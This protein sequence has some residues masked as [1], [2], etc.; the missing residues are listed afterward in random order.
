MR[1][2][3]HDNWDCFHIMLVLTWYL[4]SSVLRSMELFGP[5]KKSTQAGIDFQQVQMHAKI[6]KLGVYY[7]EIPIVLVG[8]TF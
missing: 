3:K 7:L 5:R 6:N 2:R 1:S 4:T 8:P